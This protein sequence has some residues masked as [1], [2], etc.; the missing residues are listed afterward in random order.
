M[1]TDAELNQ[2][3]SVKKY[4]PY[5][6]D[7]RWDAARGER[8]KELK[9][10]VSERMTNVTGE[11]SLSLHTPAKK[12]MGKKE[13]LKMREGGLLNGEEGVVAAVAVAAAPTADGKSDEV[14]GKRRRVDGG[15]EDDVERMGMREEGGGRKRRRRQKKATSGS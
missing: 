13:R 5:R 10:K 3:L 14:V 15:V 12:R 11:A 2:Y 6:R 8:L 4:A 7:K 9:Q 1:A